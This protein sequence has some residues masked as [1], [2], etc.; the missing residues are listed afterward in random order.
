MKRIYSVNVTG[1]RGYSFAVKCEAVNLGDLTEVLDIAIDNDLFQN[2]EDAN[3]AIVEDI[4]DSEYDINGLKDATYECN[5]YGQ[6]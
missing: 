1:E 4:T 3:Y 5:N 6:D 2:P